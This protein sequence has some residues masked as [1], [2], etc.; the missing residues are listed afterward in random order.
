MSVL[1]F[2]CVGWHDE[3]IVLLQY[4]T[5]VGTSRNVNESANIV[6]NVYLCVRMCICGCGV[7]V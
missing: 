5:F 7:Q 1:L 4:K 3:Q 6:V 2:I